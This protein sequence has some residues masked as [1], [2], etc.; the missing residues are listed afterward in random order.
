MMHHLK[1][2][3]HCN[4]R[5]SYQA[6]GDGCGNPDND[7]RYCPDCMHIINE[8]L[9]TVP[10]KFEKVELPIPENHPITIEQ[11]EEKYKK[12]EEDT[13][14]LHLYP[15]RNGPENFRYKDL[16]INWQNY[17][18]IENTDTHEKLLET[19]YERSIASGKIEDF[20]YEY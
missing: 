6:S 14:I 7:F 1:R 10:I 20:W 11:F 3:V 9:K 4:T 15:V 8:A 17:I 16:K 19:E 2:C 12:W 13:T 18:L 5:Y